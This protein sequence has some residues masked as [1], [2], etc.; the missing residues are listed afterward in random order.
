MNLIPEEFRISVVIPAYSER[1]SLIQNVKTALKNPEV[2]E[3]IILVAGAADPETLKI[4]KELSAV[5][6]KVSYHL[7]KNNPGLGYA[8]R[9]AFKLA[10]G[11]HVQI[12]YA[13]CESDPEAIAQF[14]QRARQTDADMVVASRWVPGGKV[15]NYPP[16]R[17]FFN[18]AYQQFFRVLFHTHI[19]DL[20]FGYNLIKT[21]VLRHIHWQG[22]KH[23]ITTE[24]V[25]K[26]L[27]LGYHLEEIPVVWKRRNEGKSALVLIRY[28]YYPLIAL[29]IFLCPKRLLGAAAHKSKE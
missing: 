13:D 15:Y 22:R 6:P 10:Q 24:M 26:A 12:L 25:L 8:L 1:N 7:Q 19:H 16:V 11:T 27:K 5:F 29:Y 9:E 21:S 3:V 4:S 18:R 28:L 2:L 20:T 17:Y 14:I 23:E